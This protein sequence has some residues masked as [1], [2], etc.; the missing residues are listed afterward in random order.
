MLLMKNYKDYKDYCK[1]Q[2]IINDI[3]N[4]Y[5][6]VHRSLDFYF[7][8]NYGGQKFVTSSAYPPNFFSR[9]SGGIISSKGC[10]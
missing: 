8:I 5:K 7:Q 9:F 4:F 3:T 6:F 2:E 1:W 10:L